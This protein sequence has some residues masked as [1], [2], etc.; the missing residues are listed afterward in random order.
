MPDATSYIMDRKMTRLALFSAACAALT[1]GC[2]HQNLQADVQ[3]AEQRIAQL[4]Q[5]TDA[6]DRRLTILSE[7]P[8]E[9]R[10]Y[11]GDRKTGLVAI[12]GYLPSAQELRHPGS[13]R[14]ALCEKVVEPRRNAPSYSSSLPSPSPSE[15][16]GQAAI[17]SSQPFSSSA[18]SPGGQP[19][20]GTPASRQGDSEA[21]L[22]D[23]SA[24]K[25][26]DDSV[27]PLSGRSSGRAPSVVT[28]VS[29][30]AEKQAYDAALDL[31][32]KGKHEE[33]LV[34]FRQ[35]LQQYPDGR[36]TPNALYWS[37]EALYSKGHYKEA[38][39]YFLAVSRRYPRHHKCA[40]AMLKAGMTLGRLGDRA[41]ARQQYAQVLASFPRSEAAR[42]IRARKL[43][44]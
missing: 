40:D 35:F 15:P 9:V 5:R 19:L 1:C 12:P 38:L 29:A 14:R 13:G 36:L 24:L 44:R 28:A 27:A 33:S 41:G 20:P 25:T 22:P 39:T 4:E 8:Y 42:I 21:P 30:R 11:R 16:D 23:L 26:L 43:G 10:T 18:L 17:T 34:R 31:A 32:L 2:A 7:S 37:G 3:Q 6:L